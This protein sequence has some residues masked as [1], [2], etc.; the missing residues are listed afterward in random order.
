MIDALQ[1]LLPLWALLASLGTAVIIFA[2]RD[3]RRRQRTFWNL[4]GASVKLL[5]VA[6]LVYGFLQGR[7]YQVAWEVVPGVTFHLAA[8]PLALLFAML[9][10]VLWL[11]TTV[12]A[13]AYLENSAQRA[14]FFGFFSLCVAATF[15]IALAGNL[16]TFLLFYEALT[17]ATYPLVVHRGH[18]AALAAGRTYLAY[19][20]GGGMAL[21]AGTVAL[22]AAV[23]EQPFSPGGSAAVAEWAAAAPGAATVVLAL[24]LGGVAVKA[25][26][27]PLQAWLPIA[28]VAPAPVSALLHAVAVVKAGAFGV[29]RIVQDVYGHDVAADLNVTPVLAALAA[30]T[31]LYGSL[32]ALAQVDIKRRLAFSTVSQVS[33]ITLGVAM[34]GP[35]AL[36]GGLVHLVHQGLMKI[37]LFFCAGNYAET[38]G[39][40]RIES[41]NGVGRRMPLTSV[42]FTIGAL[43]MIGFPPIAGFISK[44]HLGLGALAQELYW[45]LAVLVASTLLN[46]AYFLPVLRR[47]W[48][49]PAPAGWPGAP[50]WRR[51]AETHRWLL[52]PALFTALAALLAGVLAAAEFSP[53]NWAQ[54]IVEQEYPP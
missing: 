53:L 48:L 6:L 30:V 3:E 32:R 19:T 21:L 35:L 17:L 9:S 13:V 23:G 40:H 52:Y 24:L 2:L 46:A 51:G 31:I 47:I 1:D 14:R 39:I 7:S 36:I 50:A 43:G 28:M 37:T 49:L 26:L 5:L 27:F 25:A 10:A 11:V 54:R 38:L 29:V 41:L 42:A 33:F 15:G 12:Y 18:P 20:L 22:Y 45:V 34:G 16:F 8:D 44:W 4:F